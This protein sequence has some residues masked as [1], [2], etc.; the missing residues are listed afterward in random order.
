MIVLEL[1]VPIVLLIVLAAMSMRF[2]TDSRD[3]VPNW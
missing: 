3:D 2:G 1:L